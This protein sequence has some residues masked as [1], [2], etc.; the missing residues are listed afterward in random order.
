MLKSSRFNEGRMN[1]NPGVPSAECHEVALV[2]CY[3]YSDSE[4]PL[5]WI[6]KQYVVLLPDR[7]VAMIR[8]RKA[9]FSR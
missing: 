1:M 7:S 8:A 2:V 6:S 9:T 4:A 3:K 5:Y